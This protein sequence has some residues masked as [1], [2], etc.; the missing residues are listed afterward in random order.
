MR[1]LLLCRF[2]APTDLVGFEFSGAL[3]QSLE[4]N[5]RRALSVDWRVCDVGGMHAVLD[6]RDVVELESRRGRVPGVVAPLAGVP[7]RGN[8]TAWIVL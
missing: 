3:R 4:A 2:I 7:L 1:R 5:G 8:N 6:V